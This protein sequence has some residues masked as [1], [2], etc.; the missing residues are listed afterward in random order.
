MWTVVLLLVLGALALWLASLVTWIWSRQ[1]TPLRGNVV[2]S[3]TGGQAATA[4]V[5]LALLSLAAIAAVLAIGGWLRRIVGVLV[6]CAGVAALWTAMHD[7]PGVFGA[8]PFGYPQSQILAGHGLAVLGGLLLVAAGVLVVHGAARMPKLG[9]SYQTPA[10]A[11]RAANPDTELW[12]ALS[13]GKD[14]TQD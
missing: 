13:E 1:L 4:L 2:S 14:P 3:Q 7:L 5:P 8:H 9:A 12:Q 6:G 11:K 10:A